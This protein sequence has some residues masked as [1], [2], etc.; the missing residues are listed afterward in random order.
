[1]RLIELDWQSVLLPAVRVW[2]CSSRLW[3]AW[4]GRASRASALLLPFWPGTSGAGPLN[5][6]GIGCLLFR[7]PMMIDN[8]W[9]AGQL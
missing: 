5:P 8:V 4:P 1:V 9:P 3:V 2:A 6:F 7:A